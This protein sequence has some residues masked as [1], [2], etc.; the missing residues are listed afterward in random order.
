MREKSK[1]L[2]PG[3]QKQSILKWSGEKKC[4]ERSLGSLRQK[5]REKN[6]NLTV[7]LYQDEGVGRCEEEREELQLK[8]CNI[9]LSS[10]SSNQTQIHSHP[11]P[12]SNFNVAIQCTHF[13]WKKSPISSCVQFFLLHNGAWLTTYSKCNALTPERRCQ[14]CPISQ[15]IV[16]LAIPCSHIPCVIF[17]ATFW[18]GLAK[19]S[20]LNWGLSLPISLFYSTTCSL[21]VALHSKLF[22][23]PLN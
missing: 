15:K 8:Q 2:W 22:L 14:Y 21:S 23:L 16:E 4:K 12:L 17:F 13:T 1:W 3:T 10:G 9:T 19:I 11:N 7:R 5:K 20:K 6:S 18:Y